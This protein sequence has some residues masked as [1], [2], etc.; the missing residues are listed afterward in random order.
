[1]PFCMLRF[2][3]LECC[4]RL[5]CCSTAA[6]LRLDCCCPNY[7]Q[8]RASCW[9]PETTP[10]GPRMAT[11]S[12]TVEYM[13]CE[14]IWI[15]TT[16]TWQTKSPRNPFTQNAPSH[17]HCACHGPGSLVLSQTW[18]KGLVMLP[19]VKPTNFFFPSQEFPFHSFWGWSCVRHTLRNRPQPS[20]TVRNRS[21]VSATVRNRARE[22]AIAV[23]MASFTKVV[24][25]GGFKRR[26]ASFRLAGVVLC[27]IPICFRMC[28]KSFF[29][30][31]AIL[32]KRYQ[33]RV[34][35]GIALRFQEQPPPRP[36]ENQ[37]RP[38]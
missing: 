34:W 5:D 22:V 9:Q 6:P 18:W 35:N 37:I 10:F 31:S 7:V 21:Q 3:L 4:Y 38:L 8:L 13:G 24:T 30:A 2:L 19:R 11:P 26:A 25:F 33:V 27:D 15:D 23:P 20:A 17:L 28:P 14:L 16:A 1:M 29:V 12:E 36:Q 32:S